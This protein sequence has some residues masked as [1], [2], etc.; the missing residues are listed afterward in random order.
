MSVLV[1]VVYI[2]FLSTGNVS[3]AQFL[4]KRSKKTKSSF[5]TPQRSMFIKELE[6]EHDLWRSDIIYCVVVH[7]SCDHAVRR[8]RRALLIFCLNASI[9]HSRA[10]PKGQ[11][12]MD[13]EKEKR[14]TDTIC[15]GEKRAFVLD[16]VTF[17]ER[18]LAG[19]DSPA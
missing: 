16:Y 1:M 12:T 11:E 15:R 2:A 10:W 4:N 17:G 14:C 13:F 7:Y 8:R 19:F 5:F 9:F 18:P 6:S 3:R